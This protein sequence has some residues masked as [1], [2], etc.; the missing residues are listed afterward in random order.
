MQVFPGI[1][2]FRPNTS[3]VWGDPQKIDLTLLTSLDQLRELTQKPIHVTSG[4]RSEG[5][6]KDSQHK[7]GRA[8]DVICPGM[9]LFEFYLLAER[10]GFNGIGVYPHWHWNASQVGGLHLDV[11]P[12]ERARWMGVKIGGVQQ[13]TALTPA[14]LKGF[15][16]I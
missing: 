1:R 4:F 11:R 15:G 2:Y 13:Y 16:V 12:G 14:N 8:V 7:Y 3:D 6:T 9:D 10:V 5:S